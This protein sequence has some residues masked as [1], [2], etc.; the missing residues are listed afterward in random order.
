MFNL[1]IGNGID[2]NLQDKA[3]NTVL[4]VA[5]EQD[6][7]MVKS[8]INNNCD[9]NIPNDHGKRPIEVANSNV[10]VRLIKD[11]EKTLVPGE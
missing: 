9:P 4:H 10:I 11:Y 3:G 7:E 8:L 6:P 1:L 5:A 2:V